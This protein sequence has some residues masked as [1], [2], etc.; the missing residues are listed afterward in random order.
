MI[1]AVMAT[2]KSRIGEPRTRGDD[3]NGMIYQLTGDA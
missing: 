2:P 3:P 1:P